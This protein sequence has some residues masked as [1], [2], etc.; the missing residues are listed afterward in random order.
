MFLAS[1]LLSSMRFCAVLQP[2]Q[3]W[4]CIVPLLVDMQDKIPHCF[5]ICA[6]TDHRFYSFTQ[7]LPL[8]RLNHFLRPPLVLL[9]LLLAAT[10]LTADVIVFGNNLAASH[11]VATAIGRVL[12]HRSGYLFITSVFFG[13]LARIRLILNAPVDVVKRVGYDLLNGYLRRKE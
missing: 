8:L 4:F 3:L 7:P 11:H 5:L 10:F 2:Y 12:G 9:F 6:H 1:N 13:F